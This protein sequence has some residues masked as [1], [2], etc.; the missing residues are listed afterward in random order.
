MLCKKMF[1][2]QTYMLSDMLHSACLI[3]GFTVSPDTLEEVRGV[4]N[5]KPDFTDQPFIKSL[6]RNRDYSYHPLTLQTITFTPTNNVLL[7]Q[8]LKIN[9]VN[10]LLVFT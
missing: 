7:V 1:L 9:Q 10:Q 8:L 3:W 2:Y 4:C 6:Y 5:N